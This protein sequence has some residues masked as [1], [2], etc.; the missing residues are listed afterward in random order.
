VLYAV[1]NNI[2]QVAIGAP[3]LSLQLASPPTHTSPGLL[4]K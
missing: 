2:I 3:S 4:T 1:R